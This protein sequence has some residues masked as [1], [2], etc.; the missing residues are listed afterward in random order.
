MAASQ[1]VL[2]A[3]SLKWSDQL[4]GSSDVVTA[5]N[6]LIYAITDPAH[7]VTLFYLIFDSNHGTIGYVNAGHNPPIRVTLDGKAR[8]LEAGD[9]ILGVLPRTVYENRS[10][11]LEPG[12]KLVMFTDGVGDALNSE[13]EEYGEDR[14]RVLVSRNSQLTARQLVEKIMDDIT[15]FTGNADQADDITVVVLGRAT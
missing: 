3:E 15:G 7:F 2:R 11:E 1:A 12:E 6:E 5:A 13:G 9:L 4:T 14:L 8:R 10:L